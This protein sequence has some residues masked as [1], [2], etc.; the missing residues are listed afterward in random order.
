M[1]TPLEKAIED[2][3]FLQDK[4]DD[5]LVKIAYGMAISVIELH[6]KEEK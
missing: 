1:K 5:V 6:L 3:K 4:A 2:V